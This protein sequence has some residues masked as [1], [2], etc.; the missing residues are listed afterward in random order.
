MS[1]HT[2]IPDIINGS[3]ELGG[4]LVNWLNVK[5]IFKDKEVKGVHWAPFVFFTTWGFWN[6]F[7]YPHLEQ[8]FSFVAGMML[9]AVNTTYIIGLW[10]Y[11][12]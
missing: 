3:F 7:Y 9:V 11:W 1:V 10:R 4:A 5:Q 6:L 2:S 12:K 8:V